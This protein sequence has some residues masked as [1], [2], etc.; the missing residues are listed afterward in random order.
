MKHKEHGNGTEKAMELLMEF[1]G[2]LHRPPED[3]ITVGIIFCLGESQKLSASRIHPPP[4]VFG[5]A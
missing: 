3:I 1:S 2:K 4:S 5:R